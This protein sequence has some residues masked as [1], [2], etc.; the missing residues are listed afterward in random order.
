MLAPGERFEGHV[1][2]SVI[3]RGGFAT[4]YRA[5]EDLPGGRPVAVKVLARAHRTDEE[6]KRLAREFTVA[7]RVRHPHVVEVYRHGPGWLSMQLAAGGTVAALGTVPRRLAALEQIAD[8]LDHVHGLGIVHCD[9][10]CANILVAQHFDQPGAVLTDF[11]TA[12]LPD[13][14]APR[15]TAHVTTSMPYSAPELLTGA[16]ITAAVD[17]YALACTVVEMVSGSPPFTATSATA[18]TAAH[19]LSAPPRLS[20]RIEWVPRAFD[21]ILAKALAKDPGERY[22]TCTEMMTLMTRALTDR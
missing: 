17:E 13:D 12:H 1:V 5:H 7:R 14:P 8:A 20:H 18:L 21:S 22:P 9:V 11:G 4:V 6:T 15:R 19:L 2:D 16:A 3:G 10:K